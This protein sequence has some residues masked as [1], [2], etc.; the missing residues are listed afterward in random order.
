[1][2]SRGHADKTTLPTRTVVILSQILHRSHKD[3]T[4]LRLLVMGKKFVL[5]ILI[6]HAAT[7]EAFIK[8]SDKA[9][10]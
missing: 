6:A 2:I 4:F 1:M 5:N 10:R 8:A 7:P 9:C 3:C